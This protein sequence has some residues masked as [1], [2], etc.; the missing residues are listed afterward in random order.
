MK[1]K[2]A[3][4]SGQ[5]PQG[6][7]GPIYYR[8]SNFLKSTQR[9]KALS[10]YLTFS[11][12]N[13]KGDISISAHTMTA[14]TS[15]RDCVTRFLDDSGRL[16][17]EWL[18]PIR[19]VTRP[20]FRNE[21]DEISIDTNTPQFMDICYP[22][23]YYSI[24]VS[25]RV[26]NILTKYEKENHEFVAVDVESPQGEHLFRSYVMVQGAP[27]RTVEL[28]ESGIVPTLDDVYPVYTWSISESLP[29]DTF[30]Y[31]QSTLVKGLHHFW[32]EDLGHLWSQQLVDELG[33]VLHKDFVFIPVGVAGQEQKSRSLLS[34][35][36][37]GRRG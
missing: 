15:T 33:D 17:T 27:I 3:R 21:Y 5:V 25:E 37:F 26:K 7:S 31:I 24:L 18:T 32:D 16:K 12:L 19:A 36:S 9:S 8:M 11:R 34:R 23:G 22:R 6:Y 14:R 30:C 1:K 20:S 10:D 28:K 4:I 2:P 29:R 35:I 13:A